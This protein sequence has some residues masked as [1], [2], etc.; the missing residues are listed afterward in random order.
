MKMNA[1]ISRQAVSNP[2][3]WRKL[4]LWRNFGSLLRCM[5]LFMNNVEINSQLSRRFIDSQKTHPY[6]E[7]GEAFGLLKLGALT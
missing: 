3:S 5:L 7:E 4:S 6:F 2:K 1:I